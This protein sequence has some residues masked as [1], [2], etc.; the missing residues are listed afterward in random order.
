[1]G[2]KLK[3]Y[4]T[5]TDWKYHKTASLSK[6][7]CKS[8]MKR[9]LRYK[10][11]KHSNSVKNNI[12][13]ANKRRKKLSESPLKTSTNYNENSKKRKSL[14]I[15]SKSYKNK[16]GRYN[17]SDDEQFNP[18]CNIDH[19]PSKSYNLRKK[20]GTNNECL[21]RLINMGFYHESSLMAS[22]KFG[23]ISDAIDYLEELDIN[24]SL[25]NTSHHNTNNG[26]IIE[27]IKGNNIRRN[28]KRK[29][30]EMD[31]MSSSDTDIDA[32]IHKIKKRRLDDR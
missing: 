32:D 12:E 17:G 8:A 21:Q 5:D 29:R 19:N 9:K 6:C 28:R 20:T 2:S 15:R 23:N 14:R 18:Q 7:Q 1:M 10:N 11:I 24:H 13:N 16:L 25:E 30:H 31:L 27:Q 3:K 4:G 22:D 26:N